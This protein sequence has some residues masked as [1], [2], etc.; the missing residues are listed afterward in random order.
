[1]SKKLTPV[2]LKAKAER[3][4]Y[5]DKLIEEVGSY[6]YKRNPD[7]FELK[8]R[9]LNEKMTKVDEQIYKWRKVIFNPKSS[10]TQFETAKT[11]IE[12]LQAKK[13]E[14]F[15]KYLHVNGERRNFLLKCYNEMEK[16]KKSNYFI[17]VIPYIKKL[18]GEI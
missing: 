4:V 18:G 17:D 7:K 2:E 11:K 1:M 16:M 13:K 5:L 9:M 3:Y 15:N 14:L 10:K 8:Q 12:T 6:K